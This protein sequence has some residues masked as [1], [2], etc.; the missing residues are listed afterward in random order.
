[1][2]IVPDSNTRIRYAIDTMAV[3][4]KR[5]RVNNAEASEPAKKAKAASP[6]PEDSS[7][8]M[9]LRPRK[10][11]AAS[12]PTR[13]ARSRKNTNAET[14]QLGDEA[15]EG[16]QSELFSSELQDVSLPPKSP[17]PEPAHDE[18]E[19]TLQEPTDPPVVSSQ[20]EEQ[21]VDS[22]SDAAPEAIS[23]STSQALSLKRSAAEARAHKDQEVAAKQKRRQRDARLKSQAEDR[24][25]KKKE[26]EEELQAAAE[27]QELDATAEF[28]PQH[29]LD[30]LPSRRSPSP[31]GSKSKAF[32]TLPKSQLLVQKYTKHG[33]VK[34]PVPEPPKDLTIDSRTTV[35]VLEKQ[36]Q[37][38][39]PKIEQRGRTT[40]DNWLLGRNSLSKLGGQKGLAGKQFASKAGS[41]LPN[42]KMERR[43]WG[44]RAKF[45]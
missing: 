39:P 37:M 24:A 7:S 10:A 17:T 23:L 44:A 4:N 31:P 1:V 15:V 5:K 19:T 30:A 35:S 20:A 36:S 3:A 29:I 6:V 22:D 2:N 32:P 12:P 43:A 45:A 26:E 14:S 38:L 41:K 27:V 42:Y 8:R 28:L 40:R 13:K 16:D 33:V 21:D 9:V 34:L 11:R 18:N 25:Q